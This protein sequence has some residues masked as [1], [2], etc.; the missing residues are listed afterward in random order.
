M[1]PELIIDCGSR[2][3][4]ALLVTEDGLVLPCSQEIRQTAMRHVASGIAFDRRVTEH[5]DFI[6]EDALDVLS[7]AQPHQFF[8]RARRVGLRRQLDVDFA[9][10]ALHLASPLS[11]LSSAAALADPAVEKALPTVA[12]A[13]LDALLDPVFA[14]VSSRELERSNV[15]AVVILP[16]HAGRHARVALQ[17]V[18]R[19]RGFR[20]LTIVSREIAAAMVLIDTPVPECQVWDVSDEGL[21]IHRVTLDMEGNERRLT[22]VA[23]TT[24][25]TLNWNDWVRRIAAAVRNDA[26]RRQLPVPTLSMFDRALTAFLTGS[27]QDASCPGIDAVRRLFT[28]AAGIAEGAPASDVPVLDRLVRG[29]ASATLWLRDDASRR[30]AVRPSGSLRINT[31]RGETVEILSGGQLP[32]PGEN[33]HIRTKLA[34]RGATD[35][36]GPFLVHLLWGVDGAPEGNATLCAMRVDRGAAANSQGA[37][38]VAVHLRRS[39]GG[40]RLNGTVDVRDSARAGALRSRFTQE[41]PLFLSGGEMRK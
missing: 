10:E 27:S 26:E 16:A 8:Q 6:W 15:D 37:L 38:L 13:M 31:S 28:N 33:C 23:S 20:R 1:R 17:K 41:F 3:V 21:H 30:V 19:R 35:T 5:T 36:A 24:L 29:V 4:S 14:F 22:T 2:I 25:H 32:A 7:K 11:V 12:M 18:F 34:F 40:R 9:A 39:R